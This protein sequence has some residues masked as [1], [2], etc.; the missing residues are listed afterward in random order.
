MSVQVILDAVQQILAYFKEFDA[1]A[2]VE[3][4]NKAV[5]ELLAHFPALF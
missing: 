1:A 2:V 5:G 3:I 4:V